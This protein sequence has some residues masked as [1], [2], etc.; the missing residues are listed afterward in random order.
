[1]SGAALAPEEQARSNLYALLARLLYA[2]PDRALL[3]AIAAADPI[4]AEG[5]AAL[6]HAW[7]ELAQACAAADPEA[8][9]EEYEAVFVGIG[10]AEITL[11][12]SAY[13]GS[14]PTRN[15]LVE[16]RG[17]LAAHG[18]ERQREVPE[19]EDHLAALCEVMRH[20]VARG[21][22]NAQR[23][24]FETFLAPAAERLCDA[25]A[26]SPNVGFYRPVARLGQSFFALERN[27]FGME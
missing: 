21:D 8:V 27:A 13:L 23:A 18:L 12:A 16:L 26:H 25:I 3:A 17:F 11:Y 15:P 2:P 22:A 14:S 10:P 6:A 19:P 7:R 4:T 1:M 20:L 24:L 9:R 5:D